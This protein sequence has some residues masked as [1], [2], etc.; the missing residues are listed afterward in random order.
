MRHILPVLIVLLYPSLAS[1]QPAW[2][3]SKPDLKKIKQ[4]ESKVTEEN[5]WF[6]VESAHWLVRTEVDVHAERQGLDEA[7]AL[8]CLRRRRECESSAGD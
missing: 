5:G 3:W 7:R 8:E 1:A 2:Q 4:L 6:V